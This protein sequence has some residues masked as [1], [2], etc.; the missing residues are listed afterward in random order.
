MEFKLTPFRAI[1]AGAILLAAGFLFPSFRQARAPQVTLKAPPQ[2]GGTGG[3]V[4]TLPAPFQ[5]E[6]QAAEAP[7][8]GGGEDFSAA[9]EVG[10]EPIYGPEARSGAP[11]G[12]EYSGSAFPSG[13]AF[14]QQGMSS[15]YSTGPGSSSPGAG[16]R[17]SGMKAGSA[18]GLT[19]E[20][21]KSGS[22]ATT[23]LVNDKTSRVRTGDSPSHGHG[24][25][26]ASGAGSPPGVPAATSGAGSR[27]QAR[28]A[29]PLK[30]PGA[31]NPSAQQSSEQ[32]SPS[33]S[34]SAAAGKLSSEIIQRAGTI[35][36]EI[37][38]SGGYRF[39]GRNDCYGFVRR[40]WDPVLT[41]KG[42]RPLPVSDVASQNWAPIT[43][44]AQLTPGDVLATHQGHMWG[45]SW[46][47]GL[48]FGMVGG[49]AYSFDNSPS[50]KGGAY[51]RIAPSGVFRYYYL[52]THKLLGGR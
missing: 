5:D 40:V 21:T 7:S 39:D 34:N 49:K 31:S 37:N 43:A 42:L 2:A 10:G 9:S 24:E 22:A 8:A 45:A 41:G 28:P 23:A 4:E 11:V 33:S 19:G 51:P 50:N 47:G 30:A 14:G 29:N 32:S 17:L 27:G 25:S 38:R 52:P 46:H 48:F 36:V 16:G 15:S 3:M 26:G 44:W 35:S 6:I 13:A 20:K 12:D 18:A 1:A